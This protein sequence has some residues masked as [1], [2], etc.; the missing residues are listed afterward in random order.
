M[1]LIHSF[2]SDLLTFNVFFSPLVHLSG[3]LTVV[4]LITK[5]HV[6]RF[7]EVSTK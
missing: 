5:L 7:N 2:I 1:T 3:S 6:I 4:K